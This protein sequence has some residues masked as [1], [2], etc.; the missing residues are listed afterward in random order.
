MLLS[1]ITRTLALGGAFITAAIVATPSQAMPAFARQ[2]GKACN[3]CHFQHMPILNEY[4]MEF[5]AGG[6]TDMG[7]QA[8]VKGKELSI[9]GIFNAS[10]Y[11]KIRYQKDNGKDGT[12]N[13]ANSVK[14]THS[15]EI[16][17]PDEF[18][19]LIGGR[20]TDNI[21]FMI[22]NQFAGGG[23]GFLAGFKLPITFKV[24]KSMK[25]GMTPFL[26]DGLGASYGFEQLSTGAV[27]NIRSNEHRN[28]TSAMQYVFFGGTGPRDTA[29]A[30][31]FAA[32][33][34]TGTRVTAGAASGLAFSLWD[35]SFNVAYTR[36]TPHHLV[37]AGSN[38]G[39]LGSGL[40]RAVWTPTFG[41]WSLGIGI[42]SY[43]GSNVRFLPGG[44][45][46][47]QTMVDTRG[48]AFDVQAHGAFGNMPLGV[49]L[50]H[51]TAPGTPVGAASVNLFNENVNS[52]RATVILA[53]LGVIPNKATVS[54]GY[55]AANSGSN[56]AADGGKDNSWTLGATYQVAQNVQLQVDHST[57]TSRAD[58]VGRYGVTNYVAGGT[59][60]G[61][62]MTTFM[63]SA[64]F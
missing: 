31:P 35:P 53:E 18:A 40:L 59:T 64:G 14:T 7:K 57:R 23:V 49:Y 50:T 10:L 27:R 21:G 6:Y 9:P 2:T 48:T 29:N 56:V 55:R 16:Q 42:Q 63:L 34:G 4:G 51:A 19:L 37:E 61:S 26:T 44:D 8:E 20:V 3:T 38:V 58:G 41:D 12:D 45:N 52:R 24:G 17:F 13:A 1:R 47:Q 43:M 11:T 39:G 22:E 25:L 30:D 54:L 36:W 33:V 46:A 32:V 62:A 5:K 28:E 15:G 60:R